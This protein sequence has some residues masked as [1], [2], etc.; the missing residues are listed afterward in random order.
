MIA[1]VIEIKKDIEV[2]AKKIIVNDRFGFTL[3]FVAI[4]E[5]K[6]MVSTS[7]TMEY[8][9]EKTRDSDFD[10]ITYHN[11]AD[12]AKNLQGFKH[13]MNESTKD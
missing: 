7:V 9:S 10:K 5:D 8:D 3:N 12:M 4:L 13:V 6:S 11:M 2:I 1:K